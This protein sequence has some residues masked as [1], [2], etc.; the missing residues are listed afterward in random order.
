M[1]QLQLE[2]V[3]IGQY[4]GHSK[5][6]KTHLGYTEDPTMPNDILTPTFAVAAFFIDNVWWDEVPFPM[7]AGKALDTRWDI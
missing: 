5:G 6:E 7:K 4:K 3:V 2:D 1:R